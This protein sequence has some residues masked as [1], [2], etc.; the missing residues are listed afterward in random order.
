MKRE[1]RAIWLLL[2]AV[3]AAV[4]CS[5]DDP[6]T[7]PGTAQVR[8]V[9]GAADVPNA[10]LF[11]DSKRIAA[12]LTFREFSPYMIVISGDQPVEARV[13]N[14]NSR[15][16]A[17]NHIFANGT[18][19]TLVISGRANALEPWL[20]P[21]DNTAPA[22]GAIRVR[23]VHAAVSAQ[24]LDM[25]VT[26]PGADL[27]A[28]VPRLANAPYKSV[29]TY[30]ELPAG[31]YQVRATMPGTQTVMVDSGTLDLTNGDV[32]TAIALDKPGGGAPFESL[33]L[34]DRN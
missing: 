10:D 21:D 26:A 15:L 19:Y 7:P 29:S 2:A 27:A 6:V 11:I 12:D 3:C 9:H 13:A 28:S 8:V 30:V 14:T 17:G 20:L 4:G 23:L 22:T 25:F 31:M 24:S 1:R 34:Q 18:Q 16:F 5:D 33:V 32:I